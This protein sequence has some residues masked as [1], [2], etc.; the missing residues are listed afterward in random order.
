MD[1][2]L[3]LKKSI[4]MK[5]DEYV[6][7]K[8]ENIIIQDLSDKK[9]VLCCRFFNKLVNTCKLLVNRGNQEVDYANNIIAI[10]DSLRNEIKNRHLKMVSFQNKD[11]P[12]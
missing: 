2:F 8:G 7:I 11:S 4:Q 3:C 1:H 10:R 6:N 12:L 5:K 9:L